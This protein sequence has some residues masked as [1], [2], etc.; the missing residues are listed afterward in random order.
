M[1]FPPIPR[2]PKGVPLPVVWDDEINNWK[3][4]TGKVKDTMEFFGA[5]IDQRPSA[6]EAP[7]GATYMAVNTGE[8]WQSNG[9]EWVKLI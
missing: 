7:V 1:A 6:T 4:Y 5:T 2:D 8:V 9:F 3:V